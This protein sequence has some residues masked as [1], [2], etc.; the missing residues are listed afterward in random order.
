M[1]SDALVELVLLDGV[2]M[3]FLRLICCFGVFVYAPD[4]LASLP[5]PPSV[6]LPLLSVLPEQPTLS[7]SEDLVLDAI[8]S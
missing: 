3:F 6:L 1:E 7:L 8:M 4:V 2:Q 5:L